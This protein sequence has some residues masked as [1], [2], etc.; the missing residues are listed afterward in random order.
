MPGQDPGDAP[1]PGPQRG[2]ASPLQPV[3]AAGGSP[4]PQQLPSLSSEHS[5]S[6]SPS[7][8]GLSCAERGRGLKATSCRA[9]VGEGFW[10]GRDCWK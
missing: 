3:L 4:A 2:F 1:A 6:Q 10:R 9:C 8:T 5:L 7:G